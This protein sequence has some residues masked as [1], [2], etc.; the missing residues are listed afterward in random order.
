MVLSILGTPLG[1]AVMVVS[2]IYGALACVPRTVLDTV[3]V[4]YYRCSYVLFF[5]LPFQQTFFNCF[6]DD[7]LEGHRHVK[8]FFHR[9]TASRQWNWDLNPELCDSRVHSV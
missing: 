7:D 5:F 8:Q 3:V 2:V 6:I 9:D 1:N 4:Y